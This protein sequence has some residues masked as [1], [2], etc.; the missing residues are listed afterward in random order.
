M[1]VLRVHWGAL[2]PREQ[3]NELPVINERPC[4]LKS[5]VVGI[6]RS[7]VERRR[8]SCTRVS[9]ECERAVSQSERQKEQV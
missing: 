6:K 5:C 7:V 9:I 4:L 1:D 8:E 2:V 3:E